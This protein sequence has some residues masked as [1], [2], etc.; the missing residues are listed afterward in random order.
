MLLLYVLYYREDIIAEH[1]EILNELEEERDRMMAEKERLE[2][3]LAEAEKRA[4]GRQ[5]PHE[6]GTQQHHAA[7][8]SHT[9]QPEEVLDFDVIGHQEPLSDSRVHEDATTNTDDDS[10]LSPQNDEGNPLSLRE[11][12]RAFQDR[13]V[14][15]FNAVADIVFPKSMRGP[16]KEALLKI[17][18]IAKR[19]AI[20]VYKFVMRYIK[21]FIERRKN[22]TDQES[23]EAAMN[24]IGGTET[25]ETL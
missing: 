24:G 21:A 14:R 25:Q 17:A 11:T 9:E 19:E 3:E 5:L 6:D 23:G 15:D 10:S 8:V 22:Q 7:F 1:P 16:T 18:R 12:I 20:N 13:V 4:N 2:Q